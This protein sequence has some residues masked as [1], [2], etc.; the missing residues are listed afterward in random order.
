MADRISD[1][2]LVIA[3][4]QVRV[5]HERVKVDAVRLNPDNPRI[6]FLLNYR[7]E[8]ADQASLLKLIK[9]QP[10]Y[11]GLQKAIRK[12]GGLH[13]AII[14]SHDGTVVEG[15]TRTAAVLTLHDGAKKD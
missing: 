4:E 9:E 12:A 8:S 2:F 1:V 15:N 7:G 6:R 14:V 3:G 10:G 13:D 11:D 5:K